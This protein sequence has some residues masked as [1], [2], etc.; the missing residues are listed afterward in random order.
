MT[1]T[2]WLPQG[3]VGV[4]AGV[5]AHQA[6]GEGGAGKEQRGVGEGGGVL[7]A[8]SVWALLSK[9]GQPGGADW[10]PVDSASVQPLRGCAAQECQVAA[11]HWAAR[12][13]CPVQSCAW[14]TGAR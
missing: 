14:T 8:N 6:E 13:C 11:H 1:L 3:R 4:R 12:R 9:V 5:G 7:V 10:V 2:P